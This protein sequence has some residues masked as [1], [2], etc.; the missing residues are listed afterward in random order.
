M[1]KLTVG[2]ENGADITIHYKDHGTG[3]PVVPIHGYPLNGES[4]EPQERASL[5]GGCD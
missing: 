2:S 4:G 5:Q 1:P 3:R